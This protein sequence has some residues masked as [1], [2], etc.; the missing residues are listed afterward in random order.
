MKSNSRLFTLV[1]ATAAGLAVGANASAATI[2]GTVWNVPLSTSTNVPTQGNTP[3]PGATLEATFT[4]SQLVFT[5]NNGNNLGAFLNNAGSL[6]SI[7]YFNGASAST[8]VTNSLFEFTGTAFFTAGQSYSVTHDDGVNLYVGTTNV[9]SQPLQTSAVTQNFTYSGPV[10][11]QTFDFIYGANNNPPSDFI[12]N[13]A[14]GAV[15]EPSTYLLFASGLGF[16]GLVGR[17]RFSR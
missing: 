16:L 13:L 7:T 1:L 10:G 9:L 12:T 4:V 6:I 15:P 5:D 14:N 3:G 8:Q 17:K 2:S 11:I